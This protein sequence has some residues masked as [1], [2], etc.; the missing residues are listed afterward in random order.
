M[1]RTLKGLVKLTRFQEYGYFVVI[2]TLLGVAAAQGRFNWRL[3]VVLLANWQVVGFAFMINDIEDAPDDALLSV[4]TKYNPVSSG[5]ISPKTAKYATLIISLISVSLFAILG[6]WPLINGIANL[7]FGYL[8]SIKT[9]RLKTM[10]YFDII[11]YSLMLA[12]LPF[13]SSYFAFAFRFNRIWIWP[14]LFIV[15]ICIYSELNSEIRELEGDQPP[16]HQHTAIVLGD[17]AA[18]V[19]LMVMLGLSVSMGAVTFFLINIIPAWVMVVMALLAILFILPAH[20][21]NRRSDGNRVIQGSLQR[22]LERA[23]AL[24]L[25]L[26]FILP[27]LAELMQWRW[28]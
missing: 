1:I 5:L 16:P 18:N 28:L 14:F 21:K 8:Y 2:T 11:S 13:L 6:V 3:I 9:V 12:G 7:T 27:W 20:I 25:I 17:R 22:P 19:L 26:Q 4:K 24:A 23:A 10:A 15:S